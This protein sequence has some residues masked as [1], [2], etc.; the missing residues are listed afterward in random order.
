[1]DHTSFTK[2]WNLGVGA[3][4]QSLGGHGDTSETK[5]NQTNMLG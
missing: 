1:M 4:I 3:L 5:I 2:R